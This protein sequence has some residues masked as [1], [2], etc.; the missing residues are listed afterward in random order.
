MEQTNI[1][2]K[3]NK[4]VTSV[5]YSHEMRAINDYTIQSIILL[6]GADNK[7][8]PFKKMQICF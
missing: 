7:L 3:F 1:F 2:F 5:T 6:Q 8:T 4:S